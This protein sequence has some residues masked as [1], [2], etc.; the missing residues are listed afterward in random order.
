LS[1]EEMIK[2]GDDFMGLARKIWQRA[3]VIM[4]SAVYIFSLLFQHQK[5]N[6]FDADA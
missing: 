2:H 5:Q 4:A 6:L 3:K 1:F